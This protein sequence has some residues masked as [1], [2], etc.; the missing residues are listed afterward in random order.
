MTISWEKRRKLMESRS[1]NI[2]KI[3]NYWKMQLE[4]RDKDDNLFKDTVN[5]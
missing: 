1:I 3:S 5:K 4:N 2:H